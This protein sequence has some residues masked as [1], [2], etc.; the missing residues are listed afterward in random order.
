[1]VRQSEAQPLVMNV[2]VHPYVFG[3]P[4]RVRQLRRALRHCSG[5]ASVWYCR[6]REIADFCYGELP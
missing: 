6:P 5:Y 2:S 1:M 4:F 3:Q